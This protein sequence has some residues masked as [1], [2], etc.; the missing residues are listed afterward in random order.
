MQLF[1]ISSY[2]RVPHKQR[3]CDLY[4]IDVSRSNNDPELFLRHEINDFS[5]QLYHCNVGF[6]AFEFFLMDNELLRSVCYYF[7]SSL[8]IEKIYLQLL[9]EKYVMYTNIK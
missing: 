8:Q 2:R 9:R 5:S 6:T 3:H 7:Y 1:F 4:S